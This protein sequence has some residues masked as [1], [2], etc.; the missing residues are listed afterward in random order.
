[1][2]K[3]KVAELKIELRKRGRGVGGNK[4]VLIARLTEAIEANV[5][6]SVAVAEAPCA[7]EAGMGGLDVMARWELLAHNLTPI[8]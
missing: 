6:V 5:P 4:D 7:Q 8:P 2:K 3:F 1:L